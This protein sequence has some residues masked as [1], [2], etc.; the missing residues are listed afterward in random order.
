MGFLRK[1]GKTWHMRYKVGDRWFEKSTKCQA[2]S[3]AKKVLNE[4]ENKINKGI[5]LVSYENYLYNE[6]EADY[7]RRCEV[8][9]LRSIKAIKVRCGHLKAFFDGVPGTAITPALIDKYI[10]KRLKQLVPGSGCKT[11]S[12]TT[13]DREL[14]A[15]KTIL[16]V[17]YRNDKVNRVPHIEMQST[18]N[19]KG[20]V[21]TPKEIKRLVSHLPYH[22]G[23]FAR[24]LYSTGF[25]YSEAENLEWSQVNLETRR[26]ILPPSRTKEKKVRS[27]FI[28]DEMHEALSD[29]DRRRK[30]MRV[31]NP[32]VFLNSTG[33]N[34]LVFMK[35]NNRI[36]WNQAC[37][38]A[39][40]GYG[41]AMGD[42]TN[43]MKYKRG[44]TLHDLRYSYVW[45]NEQ[46][47]I[48][49]KDT[50]AYTGHQTQSMYDYY[51]ISNE[52]SQ[53]NL[54]KKRKEYIDNF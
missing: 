33:S 2:K 27:V 42:G 25:R 53:E 21:Y 11:I 19:P 23:L 20:N 43:E 54:N 40:L 10:K 36:R 8:K 3:D 17:G 18:R 38:K 22:L 49:R 9:G 47:G 37:R 1:R 29:C 16:N 41:Y 6:L 12:P 26:L 15:L 32:Y 52:V 31:I 44:P 7:L 46:A 28:T 24:F 5:P 39:K 34:K 4:T 35:G 45:A 14:A 51:S 50:M 13:V 30:S 48:P